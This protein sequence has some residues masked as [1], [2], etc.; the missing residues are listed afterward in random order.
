MKKLISMSCVV[1]IA[2]ASLV[3][4]RQVALAGGCQLFWPSSDP[5]EDDANSAGSFSYVLHT[6]GSSW[7]NG[8]GTP[9][10]WTLYQEISTESGSNLESGETNKDTVDIVETSGIAVFSAGSAIETT[11]SGVLIDE[12]ATGTSTLQAWDGT[13]FSCSSSKPVTINPAP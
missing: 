13:N 12:E 10:T 11:C 3:A 1:A 4:V 9:P 2:A 8:V 7:S 5:T 6:S